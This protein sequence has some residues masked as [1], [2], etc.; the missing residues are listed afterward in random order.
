MIA[1]PPHVLE[2]AGRCIREEEHLRERQG[3]VRYGCMSVVHDFFPSCIVVVGLQYN[4]FIY[5][6]ILLE[7]ERARMCSDVLV[8]SS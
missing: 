6:Y 1:T 3:E 5:V 2:E 4:L 8:D 7:L